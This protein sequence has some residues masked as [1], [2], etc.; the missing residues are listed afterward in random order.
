MTGAEIDT[1]VRV[2]PSADDAVPNAHALAHE[3]LTRLSNLPGEGSWVTALD[4]LEN[5]LSRAA[6]VQPTAHPASL[7]SLLFRRHA[8]VVVLAGP[9]IGDLAQVARRAPA[10]ITQIVEVPDEAAAR[11][12]RIALAQLRAAGSGAAFVCRAQVC[13][14]PIRTAAELR[15]ALAG[16]GGL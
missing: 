8:T 4:R 9:D 6:A 7:A 12:D 10:F 5:H 2:A 11:G 1:I 3:G 16:P 13:S 15:A 14:A